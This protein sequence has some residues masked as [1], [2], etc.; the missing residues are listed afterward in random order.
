MKLVHV[1]IGLAA[2]GAIAWFTVSGLSA[3]IRGAKPAPVSNASFLYLEDSLPKR[4][5]R[6]TPEDVDTDVTYLLAA[7]DR[8]YSGKEHLPPGEYAK[9]VAHLEALRGLFTKPQ[10]DQAGDRLCLKIAE[11]FSTVPD[12]HLQTYSPFNKQFRPRLV[13]VGP[14]VFQGTGFHLTKQRLAGRT[15]GI[16]SLGTSMPSEVDAVWKDFE[17]RIDQICRRTDALIL[18]LRGNGGGMS[19]NL[20]WLASR[21]Y[22]NP[23]RVA[24]EIM[25]SQRSAAVEAL[26]HN[27]AAFIILQA[28][29]EGSPIQDYQLREKELHLKLCTAWQSLPPREERD[30]RSGSQAPFNPKAGYNKPV[31]ILIDGGT[32]S[33]AEGGFARF[34][35][36][37]KVKIFG[38][39]TGGYIHYGDAVPLVLPRSR[40][41]V[42]IPTTFRTFSDGRFLEKVGY[43]PDV[44]VPDGQDAL[45]VAFADLA[46]AWGFPARS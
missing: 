44:R 8:A 1:A 6:L 4:V 46:R 27:E 23:A 42:S 35:S 22:G 40:I 38:T 32:A 43:T 31:Y 19:D 20:R 12:N 3:R 34:L 28:R 36:H 13:D 7:L 10:E 33:S 24:D 17:A 9:L 29:R 21:L 30:V 18:D 11:I 37:P 16:L 14:N 45:Q 2:A 26:L 5:S 25:L 41:A 39:N 15:I